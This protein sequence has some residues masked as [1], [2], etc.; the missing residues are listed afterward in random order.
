MEGKHS[1]L[2][3]AH[4]QWDVLETLCMCID[5]ARNDIYL[6]IDKKATDFPRKRI[7]ACLKKS[8][9]YFTKRFNIVWGGSQQ[10]KCVLNML[11]EA[12]AND[13][14]YYHFISGVDLPLKSQDEIHRFFEENGGKEYIGFDWPGIASG[15][16]LDRLKYYH[17]LIDII[18]KRNNTNITYRLLGKTE[19]TLLAI[20]QKL[21]IN[22]LNYLQSQFYKGSSWFSISHGLVC[23][24]ISSSNRILSSFK[25]G[26]NTDELWLQNFI[27]HSKFANHVADSNLRYI[28]WIQGMPS[29]EILT[30]KNLPELCETN[31]LFARKFNWDV[32]REVIQCI[33]EMVTK[34]SACLNTK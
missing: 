24:I 32:D 6:H 23:A 1:Y 28:V 27:M 5:D 14:T 10:M 8:K 34:E 22:R 20:Q 7:E 19:D 29:P 30:M 33:Y 15:K 31:C 12:S 13:Y 18:G 26:A 17:F 21:H 16:F 3:M 9:L 11:E 4:N 2:I 25:Y